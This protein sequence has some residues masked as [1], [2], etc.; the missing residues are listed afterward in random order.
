VAGLRDSAYELGLLLCPAGE[1]GDRALPI[2][3]AVQG[4]GD[5]RRSPRDAKNSYFLELQLLPR[6]VA[7]D[8]VEA[9]GG[10]DVGE[11]E[12]PV[13]EAEFLGERLRSGQGAGIG[14]PA[15]Q[16]APQVVSGGDGS[17]VAEVGEEGGRPEVAGVAQA[18]HPLVTLEL[19]VGLFLGQPL[20]DRP[21]RHPFEFFGQEAEVE[22]RLVERDNLASQRQLALPLLAV[23]GADRAGGPLLVRVAALVGLVG[24]PLAQLGDLEDADERVAAA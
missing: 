4:P 18:A 6:R 11:L 10:E 9:A 21:L 2:L 23:A 14:Q 5:F 16:R 24:D 17:A 13:E 7:E 22:D 3:T 8:D 19:G 12:R 1:L 20:R 15:D